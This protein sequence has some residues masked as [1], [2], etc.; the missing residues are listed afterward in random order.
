[1]L[2]YILLNKELLKRTDPATP[3]VT[4]LFSRGF[5]DIKQEIDAMEMLLRTSQFV[6]IQIKFMEQLESTNI[7]SQYMKWLKTFPDREYERKLLKEKLQKIQTLL[8][9]TQAAI[10]FG[11][12]S[13]IEELEVA[14]L[15]VNNRNLKKRIRTLRRH[16]KTL[17][18]FL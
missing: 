9:T 10:L 2:K 16:F 17:K 7:Y 18:D 1:M 13:A 15:E 8:N 5:I 12:K 4:G 3:I 11:V 14:E 6:F